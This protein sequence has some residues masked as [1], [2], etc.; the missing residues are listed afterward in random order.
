MSVSASSTTS[1]QW[2]HGRETRPFVRSDMTMPFPTILVNVV[3]HLGQCHSNSSPDSTVSRAER[4]TMVRYYI[5]LVLIMVVLIPRYWKFIL[6]RNIVSFNSRHGYLA[7][8]QIPRFPFRPLSKLDWRNTQPKGFVPSLRRLPSL[9]LN[10]NRRVREPHA[11]ER[12]HGV[13]PRSPGDQQWLRG[14][15]R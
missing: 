5:M 12:V 13:E 2:G 8:Q 9:S 3:S 15:S 4:S 1:S 7:R 6:P 11:R 14:S 10:I